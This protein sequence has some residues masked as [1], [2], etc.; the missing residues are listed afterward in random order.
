MRATRPCLLTRI[1]T[2]FATSLLMARFV[3]T[4]TENQDGNLKRLPPNAPQPTHQ[5]AMQLLQMQKNCRDILTDSH[6][7]TNVELNQRRKEENGIRASRSVQAGKKRD[8]TAPGS[9]E[10]V[11]E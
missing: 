6:Q 5:Q 3:W 1:S 2:R 4:T 7:R 10:D 8:L 9:R 11:L